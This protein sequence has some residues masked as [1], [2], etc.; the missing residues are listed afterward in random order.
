M[1]A[2]F[3]LS[4]A[5]ANGDVLTATNVNDITGTVNL[6]GNLSENAQTGTTYTLVLGDSAKVVSMT[7]AS[8]NTLTVPPNASVAFPTGT[9]III[10]QG[11]AGQTTIAAG[12]GVTINSQGA[13]LKVT[14]QYGVAT[15]VKLATNTWIA[16]G[17][18][19][20]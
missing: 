1:A 14:G 7:N 10:Y 9:Q 8:A 12:S 3:P 18:L 13:K 19:S 11:G 17:N 20:A 4:T 5:Y 15:L 6:L 2:G 16:A